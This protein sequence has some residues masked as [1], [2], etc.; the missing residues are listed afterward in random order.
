MIL[1]ANNQCN[2]QVG[3]LVEIYLKEENFL[4]AVFIMYS[5]PLIGLLLGIGIGYLIFDNELLIMLLGIVVMSLTFVMIRLNE[6]RFKTE[7]FRPIAIKN[8]TRELED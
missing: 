4:K 8:Q 2:A 3:D 6:K 5:I 7:K 1:E